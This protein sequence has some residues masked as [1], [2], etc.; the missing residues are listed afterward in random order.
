MGTT[1]FLTNDGIRIFPSSASL[2]TMESQY[3]FKPNSTSV[4]YIVYE[5]NEDDAANVSTTKLLQNVTL[6][7]AVSLDAGVE[8]VYYDGAPN[9]SV[10]TSAIIS[11]N[12]VVT[13]SNNEKLYL[14]NDHYLMTG[15]QYYFYSKAHYFT[16]VCYS[17]EQEDDGV[18]KLHLRHSGTPEASG[19]ITTSYDAF[20]AGYPYVYLKA[21]DINS[22]LSPDINKIEIYAQ[23]N[24]YSNSLDSSTETLYTVE[25][26][27]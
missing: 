14:M 7:Y 25:V 16:L 2:A 27:N 20:G 6:T 15:I 13:T 24:A 19:V 12:N 23:T 22:L 18:L 21:F 11:L 17:D 8:E 26:N 1:Y 3:Q 9:D 4:A 5:Y 10:S